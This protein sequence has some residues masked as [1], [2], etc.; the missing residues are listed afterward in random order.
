MSEEPGK[1][2]PGCGEWKPLTAYSKHAKR[3]DGRQ[4]YCKACIKV[5]YYEPNA[6]HIRAKVRQWKQDNP[7]RKRE[8]DRRYR[9]ENPERIAAYLKGYNATHRDRLTAQKRAKYYADHA[10][11]KAKF[12]ERYWAD[13]TAARSKGRRDYHKH[14]TKRRQA[15]RD[16]YYAHRDYSITQSRLNAQRNPVRARATK[17]AYKARKRAAPGRYR[18]AEW[19]MLL[20]WF[21]DR[22]LRCGATSRI[23]VD[24][25]VALAAGGTNYI[26]NL[27]PLCLPC[28]SSKQ[29]RCHDYRDPALLAMFLATL[30]DYAT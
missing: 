18:A 23:V 21:G 14:A 8:A 7:E 5:R 15:S 19:A 16:W 6:D 24:H 11:N 4:Y 13:P 10:A 28:N 12:R 17:H 25:V 2:C 26:E 1:V 9:A 29:D 22:C 27:Q 30:H 3:P 20:Q